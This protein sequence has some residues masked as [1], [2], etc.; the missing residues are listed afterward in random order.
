MKISGLSVVSRMTIAAL[1]FVCQ[2]SLTWA[3][4]TLDFF[5]YGPISYLDTCETIY[6]KLGEPT[7]DS[8]EDGKITLY[9]PGL[10]FICEQSDMRLLSYEVEGANPNPNHLGKIEELIG[11]SKFKIRMS[12][13]VPAETSDSFFHYD[14]INDEK[15][16]FVKILIHFNSVELMD[17]Y[18][19]EF[20]R[21]AM[22]RYYLRNSI[23]SE[24]Y[25]NAMKFKRLL[26]HFKVM[27]VNS[28]I[29]TIYSVMIGNPCSLKVRKTDVKNG[30]EIRES[31]ADARLNFDK[32]NVHFEIKGL[33]QSNWTTQARLELSDSGV[34]FQYV[35][36]YVKTKFSLPYSAS[37]DNLEQLKEIRD[38]GNK[39]L[40]DCKR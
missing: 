21:D 16:T 6:K 18:T 33:N 32:L 14:F 12:L 37:L 17:G 26:D 39:L 24:N 15:V 8:Y 20:N 28:E 9:Y 2:S 36:D 7:Q 31:W 19:V 30:V 11:K 10:Y 35:A 25:Q 4:T 5:N 38:L 13:G 23:N 1:L 3:V 34:D 22:R 40:R 29:H 27:N